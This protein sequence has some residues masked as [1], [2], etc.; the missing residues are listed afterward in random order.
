MNAVEASS[1]DARQSVS[2][3]SFYAAMRMLPNA[4]RR[5][6]FDI[7]AFCRAVDDVA[8]G[9]GDRQARLAELAQWRAD[10]DALF[11][12]RPPSRVSALAEPIRAYGL[13]RGDFLSIIDGMEMDVEADIRAPDLATLD[14][15]CDR[16][17][18]AVGRL[19]VRVFGMEVQDGV[20]LAFH[21]GRALQLTNIL[22]DLDEDAAKGRLY[23]PREAL[24]AAGITP[25]EPAMALGHPAV[26]HAC[27]VVADRANGHYAEANRMMSRYPLRIVRAP[28][29]M[30]AVYQ[31]MLQRL[32]A[33]G[34][35]PPRATI[36]AGR[37]RPLWLLVRRR[38]L[39][40]APRRGM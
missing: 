20:S 23:L 22:R 40:M 1:R 4:Q 35:A 28:F 24:L 3:S 27:A 32:A 17:A 15:Y 37:A 39:E 13:Q 36:R 14:L 34:W 29:V 33:R 31:N 10:I 9:C 25:R 38:A 7:Y 30:A 26:G 19:S 21:L 5:A 8:D 2:G 6:M 16:V 11:A 12:G 18:C